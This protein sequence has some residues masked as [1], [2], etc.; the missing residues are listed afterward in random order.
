LA[1]AHLSIRSSLPARHLR[2]PVSFPPA[3]AALLSHC[4]ALYR[5]SSPSTCFRRSCSWPP[6]PRALRST[7]FPQQSSPLQS[8]FSFFAKPRASSMAAVPEHATAFL[9]SPLELCANR[10]PYHRR[11]CRSP[12]HL[13]V[14][15]E[16]RWQHCRRRPEVPSSRAPA[17]IPHHREELFAGP[18]HPT[19]SPPRM[20]KP[21]PPSTQCPAVVALSTSAAPR[22]RVNTATPARGPA[23]LRLPGPE[24]RCTVRRRASPP[25]RATPRR[26][27]QQQREF[28]RIPILSYPIL[29]FSFIP[30]FL[31]C[32]PGN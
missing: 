4:G 32:S 8:P 16:P 25:G 17:A 28:F 2:S 13:E 30:F 11:W 6:P 9:S 22:R 18:S 1:K 7:C 10:P 26:L 31:E 19:P 23:R 12:H 21:R 3:H 14:F 24:L 15:T 20:P 5:T 29:F 27:K